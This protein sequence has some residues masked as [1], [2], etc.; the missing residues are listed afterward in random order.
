MRKLI[1]TNMMSLDGY[2]EGPGKDVMALFSYRRK[3]YPTDQSFDEYN[4][5]RL[6]SADTLVLGRVT[7][8]SFKDYW[9]PIADDPKADPIECEISRLN[10]AIE[11]VVVSDSLVAAGVEAWQNSRVIR[12]SQAH[13]ELAKL[14]RKRGN[15]ILV[16]GSHVL[17]NDLLRHH[18]VDELHLMTGPVV[19]GG[20]TPIFTS[21]PGA[22]LRLIDVFTWRDSGNVLTRYK[23][24][25]K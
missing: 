21:T 14:K 25:G 3:A 20:G 9:P 8:Q 15:D 7:Y 12:R 5:E 1:V 10:N 13:Q 17:W 23:V 2:Y 6:R 19:L 16:F 4:A 22:T 18:L 24:A 11:K